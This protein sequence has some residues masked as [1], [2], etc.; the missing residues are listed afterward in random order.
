MPVLDHIETAVFMDVAQGADVTIPYAF[1]PGALD[2]WVAVMV[3]CWHPGNTGTANPPIPQDAEYAGLDLDQFKSGR[4]IDD[5]GADNVWAGLWYRHKFL[6]VQ[7]LSGDVILKNWNR[8]A[9]VIAYVI[10]LRGLSNFPYLWESDGNNNGIST[11]VAAVCGLG[12]DSPFSLTGLAL[13]AGAKVT[14]ASGSAVILKQD[15]IEVA[16]GSAM[17]TA[18]V[19]MPAPQ[20]LSIVTFDGNAS[21]AQIDLSPDAPNDP[22][23]DIFA[24]G[25]IRWSGVV[26]Q[27]RTAGRADPRVRIAGVVTE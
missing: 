9:H 20:T 7:P 19:Q 23:Q 13:R 15:E 17:N 25:A 1:N 8:P 12:P 27:Q 6:G 22:G 16:L 3:F 21:S 14:G 4:S 2:R 26:G 5:P 24:G 10:G 18:I 11:Q